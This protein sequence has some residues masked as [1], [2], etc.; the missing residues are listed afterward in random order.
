MSVTRHWILHLIIALSLLSGKVIGY[1]ITVD[2]TSNVAGSDVPG[3]R[4]L[5]FALTYANSNPGPHTIR[6]AAAM[7]NQTFPLTQNFT[8]GQTVTIDG[9]ANTGGYKGGQGLNPAGSG[10]WEGSGHSLRIS[11]STSSALTFSA[12]STIRGIAFVAPNANP[13]TGSIIFSGGTTHLMD[14]CYVG[15]RHDN[16]TV[17]MNYQNKA[18]V[19]SGG[20]NVTIRDSVISNAGTT[21]GMGLE[22]TSPNTVLIDGC[23]IGTNPAGTSAVANGNGVISSSV[24]RGGI[25]LGATAAAT[26]IQN[27]LISGNNGSGITNVGASNVMVQDNVIG[28][29]RTKTAVLRNTR[30]GVAFSGGG[31]WTVQNNVI[32][33]NNGA[34]VYCFRTVAF[35]GFNKILNNIIGTDKANG[36]TNYGN[37]YFGIYIDDDMPSSWIKGNTI[38]FTI[39]NPSGWSGQ[40]GAAGLNSLTAAGQGIAVGPNTVASQTSIS[41]NSIYNNAGLGIDLPNWGAVN[42]NDSG[43]GDT[44][45]NGRANFPVLSTAVISASTLT[46]TGWSRPGQVIEFYISDGASGGFGQGRTYIYTATEGVSDGDATTST[47]GTASI[48]GLSQ[49]TDNTNRFSFAIPMKSLNAGACPAVGAKL[50]AIGH[51][52]GSV[53]SGTSNTSEFSGQVTTTG[54]NYTGITILPASLPSTCAV[55][56]PYEPRITYSGGTGAVTLAL[57]DAPSWMTFDPSTGRIGGR[58][59]TV[60]AFSFTITAVDTTGCVSKTYTVTATANTVSGWVWSDTNYDGIWN[61]SEAAI[62]GVTVAIYANGADTVPHTADDTIVVSTSTGAGGNYVLTSGSSITSNYLRISTVPSGTPWVTNTSLGYGMGN[63]LGEGGAWYVYTNALSLANS[64]TSINFGFAAAA[65]AASATNVLQNAS[66]ESGTFTSDGVGLAGSPAA[67][68]YLHATY[69]TVPRTTWY[70]N[71]WLESAPATGSPPYQK[72]RWI[73]TTAAGGAIAGTKL[74]YQPGSVSTTAYGLVYDDARMLHL[75]SEHQ[76]SAWV[77]AFD[78]ANP[79]TSTA[80]VRFEIGHPQPGN[81]TLLPFNTGTMTMSPGGVDDSSPV[82]TATTRILRWNLPS[83][84]PKTTT[85]ATYTGAGGQVLDWRSLNWQKIWVKFTPNSPILRVLLSQ[86]P[87]NG[88]TAVSGGAVWDAAELKPTANGVQCDFGDAGFTIASPLTT[89]FPAAANA[90]STALKIGTNNTDGETFYPSTGTATADNST[91]SGGINDE[92]LDITSRAFFAGSSLDYNVPITLNTATI[93]NARLMVWA[94]WDG[95][96]AVTGADE[97]VTFTPVTINNGTANYPVTFNIPAATATTVAITRYIRFR[98]V[99]GSDTPTFNGLATTFGEVEDYAVTINPPLDFGDLLHPTAAASGFATTTT[100]SIVSTNL[101]LGTTIDAEA[102]VTP[103]AAATVDDIT[104]T[105]SVDDEDGITLLTSTLTAGSTATLRVNA[106]NATLGAAYLHA[107]VDFNNDGI[108]NNTVLNGANGGERLE[109]VRTIPAGT[110]VSTNQNITFSVPASASTGPNRGIRIRLTDQSGTLPTGISGIGEVEDHVA[111]IYSAAGTV[112]TVTNTGT[113]A[114]TSGTLEWA[115]A[116]ANLNA[117]H[118]TIRFNIAGAGPHVINMGATTLAIT[119]PVTIDGFSQNGAVLGN[120]MAGTQHTINIHVTS[121]NSVLTCSANNTIIRGLAIGGVTGAGH[122]IQILPGSDGCLLEGLYIGLAAN[123][124]TASSISQNGIRIEAGYGHIVRNSAVANSAVGASSYS[125]ILIDSSANGVLVENS[126]IGTNATGL[127]AAANATG[128]STGT[129]ELGGILIN[130]PNAIIRNNLVSGNSGIGILNSGPANT[131]I[132]NNIVGMNRTLTVALPNSNHGIDIRGGTNVLIQGNTVAGNTGTGIYLFNSSTL[133]VVTVDRNVVGTIGHGSNFNFGNHRGGIYVDDD[134]ASGSVIS[135]NT[136]AFNDSTGTISGG[137]TSNELTAGQGLWLGPNGAATSVLITQNSFYNNAGLG[138]DIKPAGSTTANTTNLNDNIDADSGPNDLLNFPILSTAAVSGSNLVVTGFVGAGNTVEVFLADGDGSNFG[139][140]K[141]YLFTRTEGSADDTDATTGTY[142]NPVN[143]L[144]QGAITTAVNRFTFTVPLASLPTALTSGNKATATATTY[145][146]PRKTSEFSGVVTI[147][148]IP[149]TDFGDHPGFASASQIASGDIRIGTNPTDTENADLGTADD[150]VG[151]DDEDLTMPVFTVGSSTALSIPVNIPVIGNL[152]GSTAMLNLFVDWNGDGDVADQ[153]ETQTEQ[154]VISSGTRSFSLKPPYG[155]TAGTKYLRIRLSESSAVPA[156]AGASTLKGEVEDYAVSVVLGSPGSDGQGGIEILPIGTYI[157]PMDNALQGNFNLKSYGLAVRL[158]HANVPLKWII[159]PA[160]GKDGVDFAANA[161]RIKPTAIA[162]SNLSFRS[163][164]IAIHP[165]FESQALAVINAYGNNVAV[166]QLNAA[167]SVNVD[168]TLI[169]KPRVAVFDQGGNGHLHTDILLEAG[170]TVGT[171]YQ[172]LIDATHI[173]AGSCFTSATEPHTGHV[174]GAEALMNFLLSGGNFFG[175]CEAVEHYLGQGLLS[176]F[177]EKG[178]LGGTM[179]FDN[180]QDPMAQF[181]GGLA[182]DG[183]SVESF[184]M[185]SNPGCRIAYSSTDG[186]RYKAYAGRVGGAP[187]RGGWVQYLAG[188]NYSGTDIA[189]INGRRMLLNSVLRPAGRPDSCN[190]TIPL[191]YGDWNGTDLVGSYVD[192]DRLRLGNTVEAEMFIT[193]NTNATADDTTGIDDE[194]GVTM[195]ATLTQAATVTI[196]V[197]VFNNTGGTRY[198]HAW[199]DFNNDHTFD[200]ALVSAGGERLEAVRSVASSATASNQNITFVVPTSA[201]VGT[202]RGVRF[203]ISDSTTTTPTSTPTSTGGVGEVEDYIVEIKTSLAAGNLVYV[204]NNDNGRF[205]VG[206]GAGNIVVQAKRV[207]DNIVVG[208]AITDAA[209]L[210]QITGLTPGNYY[211][212]IPASEFASGKSLFGKFSMVGNGGDSGR[213]DDLDESGIDDSAPAT[214]GIRSPNIALAEAGE[215]TAGETGQDGNWDDGVSGR[216]ADNNTDLTIDFGFSPCY[217]TNLMVN[218]SFENASTTAPQWTGTNTFVDPNNSTDLRTNTGNYNILNWGYDRGS[219]IQSPTRTTDGNRMLFI[220]A[221]NRAWYDFSIDA[222]TSGLPQLASGKYYTVTFDWAPFDDSSAATSPAILPRVEVQTGDLAAWASTSLNIAQAYDMLDHASGTTVSTAQTTTSWNTLN[223]RRQSMSFFLPTPIAGQKAVQILLTMEQATGSTGGGLIDNVVVRETCSP[224]SL[225]TVGNLV[226]NDLNNDGN[227]DAGEGV[228]NVPVRLFRSTQTKNDY[229]PVAMATTNTDGRYLFSGLA[230][231][232]Y[233]IHI[234]GGQFG[235]GKPLENT[236]SIAPAS[237]TDDALDDNASSNDN[238]IDSATPATGGIQSNTFTLSIGGEPTGETGF[239]NNLDDASDSNGNLTV[240]FG[241]VALDFGDWNGSGALTTTTSSAMSA[242]LRL[243]ATVD[244]EAGVTPN[245]PATADGADE[246]GVTMPANITQGASVTIPV[247]VYNNNTTGKYLQAWIDFNNDGT[248]NNTDVT[249]GGER[250]HNAVT[251]ANAAAQ[252]VNITF[253]VPAAASAGTQRGVRFRISDNAATTPTSSGAVGEIEDYVT[254]I[255]SDPCLA[256]WVLNKL[257]VVA[258]NNLTMTS[259]GVNGRLIAKNMSITTSGINVGV[260]AGTTPQQYSFAVQTSLTQSASSMNVLSGSAFGYASTMF[261]ASGLTVTYPGGGSLLTTP[262]PDFA[263]I[264][265]AV[266]AEST[267]YAGMLANGTVSNAATAY[268]LTVGSG[269]GT[270]TAV[271]V[272][273]AAQFAGASNG[274][275]SINLNGQNP[276]AII[277]NVQGTAGVTLSNSTIGSAALGPILAWNFFENT[278]TVTFSNTALFGSFLAPLGTINFGTSAVTGSVAA[279]NIT[280]PAGSAVNNP[281]WSGLVCPRPCTVGNLIY[282]DANGNGAFDSGEGVDGVTV[283]L[284]RTGTPTSGTAIATAT[285]A[286]GGLYTMTGI[287]PGQYYLHIPA[288]NFASGQPL[289][290][291]T[292]V[293]STSL[294]D[295]RDHGVDNAAPATNGISSGNFVLAPDAMPTDTTGET[296]VGNTGDNADDDNG[297]LTIDFGFIPP[298][299]RDFG[300]APSYAVATA[301]LTAGTPMFGALVDYESTQPADDNTTGM[302]ED[303]VYVA[304]VGLQG[305][306]LYVNYDANTAVQ[307][308]VNLWV[309]WNRDGDFADAGEQVLTNA[310][311]TTRATGTLKIPV[312]ATATPG[313]SWLRARIGSASG[314]GPSGASI[315]GEVE[316]HAVTIVDGITISGIVFEDT[317][318]N[319]QRDAGEP[320]IPGVPVMVESST[321]DDMTLTNGSGNY[322]LITGPGNSNVRIDYLDSAGF[323]PSAKDVGNDA[324][325]SDFAA[326][327]GSTVISDSFTFTAASADVVNLS[328]GLVPAANTK[329]YFHSGIRQPDNWTTTITL[330]KFSVPNSTLVNA[331]RASLIWPSTDFYV[332]NQAVS[333]ATITAAATVT[334]TSSFPSTADLVS[335]DTRTIPQPAVSLAANDGSNAF[336]PA[337]GLTTVGGYN[338]AAI[339]GFGASGFVGAGLASYIGADTISVPVILEV[340]NTWSGGTTYAS[341]ITHDIIAAHSV[342]YIYATTDFGDWAHATNSSGAATATASS[343]VTS[344][345]RLGATVDAEA[346]VTP[347]AAADADGTDEDGVTMPASIIQGASVTI[348]VSVFNNNT[349]GKYLQAWIDFD[350]DGVFNNTDVASGGERIHNAVTAANA[351]QQTI[352]VTF[353]VP[354]VASVG[355]QRGVRFRLTDN[356]ATTPVSSGA[357]GETEDYVVA[358]AAPAGS[359]YGDY[360]GFPSASSVA[361][362]NLRMGNTVDIETSASTNAAATGDDT[363]DT[364]DEDGASTMP[365][366]LLRGASRVMRVRVTNNTVSDGYLNVWVDF[367]RNGVLTDAGERIASDVVVA[368]GVSGATAQLPFVVPVGAS[369][370]EAGVRFRLSD[371]QNPSPLG[372]AGVGEVEDYVTN[373]IFCSLVG[374]DFERDTVDDVPRT[375]VVGNACILNVPTLTGNKSGGITNSSSTDQGKFQSQNRCWATWET[376]STYT[377]TNKTWSTYAPAGHARTIAFQV[378]LDANSSGSIDALSFYAIRVDDGTASTTA[379]PANLTVH[380]WKQ[381][382]ANAVWQESKTLTPINR[383]GASMDNLPWDS[384]LLT[385]NFTGSWRNTSLGGAKLLFEIHAVAPGSNGSL[386]DRIDFDCFCLQGS[387]VCPNTDYGDWNGSGAATTTA[388]SIASPNLRLG[389]TVDTETSVTPDAAATAD[390]ADEDGVTMPLSL[391]QGSSATIPVSVFNNNTAGTYLQAWIDFNNDGVFNNTDA[392][393]GGDRIYNALTSASASTQTLNV[394]FTIPLGSSIGAQRGVRF[395]LSNSAATT[396]TSSG[397][398]GEIED[399]VVSIQPCTGTEESQRF[400]IIGLANSGQGDAIALSNGEIGADRTILSQGTTSPTGASFLDNDGVFDQRW[401]DT[402][403]DGRRDKVRHPTSSA[404][405]GPAEVIDYS[406]SMALPSAAGRIAVSDTDIFADLGG[407]DSALAG[408]GVLAQTSTVAAA[409]PSGGS[410]SDYFASGRAANNPNG[411]IASSPSGATALGVRANINLTP[412]RAEIDNLRI[413][414]EAQSAE[415]TLNTDIVSRNWKDSPGSGP[416]VTNVAGMDSNGDGIVIVDVN[417][418]GNNF[419]VENSDWFIDGPSGVTVIIRVT[420]TS[421]MLLSNAT[422]Q[423]GEGGIRGSGVGTASIILYKGSS[424][425]NT[426]DTVFGFSNVVLDHVAVWELNGG[427]S[428]TGGNLINISNGQGSA[429]FIGSKIDLANCRFNRVAPCLTPVASGFDFGDLA[430]TAPGTGTGNYETLLANNGPRHYIAPG[431]KLGSVIDPEEDGLQ[432]ANA[433]G[434]GTDDDGFDPVAYSVGFVPGYTTNVTISL[435]N[436]AVAAK[437][438]GFVDLNNDGDFADSGEALATLTVPA[439]ATSVILP[440]VIPFSSSV[441]T[442]TPLGMRLRLTHDTLVTTGGAAAL[443]AATDGEVED[444][445]ITI[446]SCLVVT[447]TNDSGIGSLRAAIQCANATPGLDT[448]TFAISGGGVKTIT[449]AS[450]LPDITDPLIIDGLSQPGAVANSLATGNNATLLIEVNGATYNVF[451]FTTGSSG[452]S[453]KGMIINRGAFGVLVDVANVTILGNFIGTNAAGASAL[454]NTTGISIVGVTGAQIGGTAP[455]ARNVISGNAV[456]GIEFVSGATGNNIQGNYIGTNA[457]GTGAVA[458][459]LS[460]IDLASGANNNTIGGATAGSGNVVSGNGRDGI[461]VQTTG[462]AIHGNYVGTNAAGTGLLGNGEHGIEITS[463]SNSIGGVNPGEPNIIA[464][465]GTG[466]ILVSGGA[467]QTVSMRRNSIYGNTGPGIDLGTVAGISPNNGTRSSS[468]SN[469]DMDYPIITGAS[470]SGTDLTVSGFVGSVLAGAATWS[471]SYVEI[472][473]TDNSPADQGGEVISGDGASQ[474]HGEGRYYIGT[475][476]TNGV[477]V[478]SGTV[479]IPGAVQSLITGTSIYTATATDAA[480]NTSEFGA[481]AAL[482]FGD[483]QD[484]LASTAAGDYQTRVANNGPRHMT[485][486]ALRL[487]STITTELD[488]LSNSTATGDTGDDGLTTLPA[489]TAGVNSTPFNIAVTN[490]GAAAKLSVWIDFNNNGNFADAGEQVASDLNV[491]TSATSVSVPSIAIP[492]AAVQGT[493]LGM[494]VRLST[495]ASLT[496]LGLALDGEVEDYLISILSPATVGNMV[497]L[498]TNLDGILN[499]GEGGLGGVTVQLHDATGAAVSGKSTTTAAS[500]AWSIS[501][502]APGLYTVQ[503]AIPNTHTFSLL[504]QGTN[505]TLDSDVTPYNGRSSGFWL[506]SGQSRTDIDAGVCVIPALGDRVWRD[507]NGDGIQNA[508]ETTGVSGV[509][510]TLYDSLGAPVAGKTATSNASGAWSIANV[511]AGTY[512]VGFGI[513]SGHFASPQNQGADDLV[514]SD[515]DSSGRTGS[516][517]IGTVLRQYGSYP[518]DPAISTSGDADIFWDSVTT[519]YNPSTKQLRLRTVVTATNSADMPETITAVISEGL[520]PAF[521]SSTHAVFFMDYSTGSPRLSVYR[522][523]FDIAAAANPTSAGVI[524]NIS[525]TSGAL[526]VTTSGFT[527]TFDFTIDATPIISYAGGSWIGTGYDSKL[528]LSLRSWGRSPTVTYASN[529]ITS[530]NPNWGS[531]TEG[532][533]LWNV[534]NFSTSSGCFVARTDIDFG[535]RPDTDYGDL[536][537]IAAGTGASNYETLSINNGPAHY[538]NAN[539]RLGATWDGESD[540]QQSSNANGDDNGGIDDED[541]IASFPTFTQGNPASSD[542]SVSVYNNTGSTAKLFGFIDWNGDGDFGDAGEVLTPVNVNSSATLQ[543]VPLPA[544]TVPGNAFIGQVGARFRLSSDSSLTAVGWSGSGEVE[545]YLITMN[546][547]MDV[548]DLVFLDA[549]Q[550]GV[551]DAGDSGLGGLTLELF[552]V[553]PDN[554][555]GGGDDV[556]KG[557][558]VSAALTGAYSFTGIPAGKY[559]IRIATPPGSAAFSSGSQVSVDNG[560][561]QDNNGV[562]P[563]GIGTVVNSPV[564]TL[565]TNSEPN[566]GVGGNNDY[567]IDFGFRGVPNPNIIVEYRME[568]SELNPPPSKANPTNKTACLTQTASGDQLIELGNGITGITTNTGTSLNGPKKPGTRSSSIHGWDTTADAA[569]T[570]VRTSLDPTLDSVSARF[571]F[572][573]ATTGTL[574]NVCF[575]VYRSDT[576]APT[577]ARAALTWMEGGAYR[578]AYSNAF[579]ITNLQSWMTANLP[580]TSF[581]SGTTAL[582][583]GYELAGKTFL[584]EVY[585][586]G[587]TGTELTGVVELDNVIMEGNVTCVPYMDYGDLRD[588]VAGPASSDYTTLFANDGP[589]HIVTA[590]LRIGAAI[591]AEVD[592]LHNAAADGDSGDDAFSVLPALTAGTSSGTWSIP[593]VNS[594]ASANFSLWID[595][596]ANGSFEDAGEKVAGDL[597]VTTGAT[598]VTVPSFVVPSSASTTGAVGMRM[599]LSTTVGLTSIGEAPNGEVEDYVITIADPVSLGNLV[600]HDANL[601]GLN[602]NGELGISGVSVELYSTTD[603]NIGN[604]DDTYLATTITNSEGKYLFNYLRAGK[605]YIKIQPPPAYPLATVNVVNAD[606]QVNDDNN[607]VQVGL[608]GTTIQSPVVTL[609]QGSESVADGDASAETDLTVDIGLRPCTTISIT[610]PTLPPGNVNSGYAQPLSASGG[611]GSYSFAK[612]AGNLPAGLSLAASGVVSGTPAEAGTFSFT[613]SATDVLGCVGTQVVNLTIRPLPTIHAIAKDDAGRYVMGGEFYE[614][615]GVFRTNLVRLLPDGSV[616]TTFNPDVPNGVVYCIAL[617]GNAIYV[618]GAFTTW[619]AATQNLLVKLDATTGSRDS[620]FAGHVLSGDTGAVV[621]AIS[622]NGFYVCGRFN[623]PSNGIAALDPSTGAV[624]SGFNPAGPGSGATLFDCFYDGSRIVTVGDFSTFNGSARQGIAPLTLTGGFDN[625]WTGVPPANAPARSLLQLPLVSDLVMAGDFTSY[626]GSSGLTGTARINNNTGGIIPGYTSNTDLSIIK[627]HKVK[628]AQ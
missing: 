414:I 234:E 33:G 307:A 534:S 225:L 581:V 588:L 510:V 535:L 355:T 308:Y 284:F 365:R 174:N 330:P 56:F 215:P 529:A 543:T 440:V 361:S 336:N 222:Q 478:F 21:G 71:Y 164:P 578:T 243:G 103:N 107:W 569:F 298:P 179:T 282:S 260:D 86:T 328:A 74:I 81:N 621:H 396:P 363:A 72:S 496:S 379:S 471:G 481:M 176:G 266:D 51:I 354:G 54:T 511:A 397:A 513:P 213:D 388:S 197:S 357:V 612:I 582:P 89:A 625:T 573:A 430:D 324:T 15:V 37:G 242:N 583:A 247:S 249:S 165:G 367:N 131:I 48:N 115:I 148:N 446:T 301:T 23:F 327:I 44:G 122:G 517:T 389:A 601:D 83:S 144:N 611:T 600:W 150:N 528:G 279:N 151:T 461:R 358:I 545:D 406:G 17:G 607:G 299:T 50:T 411:I 530:W 352:N 604:G 75:G 362:T 79:S 505:R 28:L 13:T 52:G 2:T 552:S 483:L 119:Q 109:A 438:Y 32:A 577:Q 512:S 218:G 378:D 522:Y 250:V 270:G 380:V 65:S 303:G 339:E 469:D 533:S 264:Y 350:N 423:P 568:A 267:A 561:D 280:L 211:L 547:W 177:V 466:G 614:V 289:S 473:L 26:T 200:D 566:G 492:G 124:T 236:L 204:D 487:G 559:F 292:S 253:T 356:N 426:S 602:N 304:S 142:G 80:R 166:H 399:Y 94:D 194:D 502:I 541:G 273:S 320:G 108:F 55:N 230:P 595:Y 472:F 331:R 603:G 300:D 441:V 314:V 309:D 53:A 435:A 229:P 121:T 76:L 285:T 392:S 227:Y 542:I 140:G 408:V 507:D 217:R 544:P 240:D 465:N 36:S 318:N 311:H 99:E 93:P 170:L 494:R 432:S 155:T 474:P 553:G 22:I 475:L 452:S 321:Y 424:E 608:Q 370:G 376:A 456:R 490:T 509:A 156:F 616:D 453:V 395:R 290:G 202:A 239:A 288:S 272:M 201:S 313:A 455:A 38:C 7:A 580:L 20:S 419:I 183:G 364:D 192:A 605:Y 265:A 97:V 520:T 98:V 158:L 341:K 586:Y 59:T 323:T 385:A 116:Q 276:S 191:D 428:D 572:N 141:T 181:E 219:W 448:I 25:Y 315:D 185:T 514:D 464:G 401:T 84:S 152:S 168:A 77:A 231:G 238:G 610:P 78:P 501:G 626:G 95:D 190:L 546:P 212:F 129:A 493:N 624:V 622:D 491:A 193:P 381:V 104:N 373:I 173:T 92:D 606:D 525:Q 161:S 515:G 259:S 539:L 615:N 19:I 237:P 302:D 12:S 468:Q 571:T 476:T 519:T 560:V 427:S 498:D 521:S 105:G 153:G 550:N 387:L 325:D 149:T 67:M 210:Y 617:R 499:G 374:W 598:V 353:S 437:L 42:T 565:I 375:G 504:H 333:A 334:L 41:Q 459:A 563:G 548:G 293:V 429:Q 252:T 69:P 132:Q 450:E 551:Y 294:L 347:N 400:L 523:S 111:A 263:G 342:T 480:G 24:Y 127:A 135:N 597:V 537:D 574:G 609:T 157:I 110:T 503:F 9:F 246:D 287:N 70:P 345:L 587:G 214:N 120:L 257:N 283:R 261:S 235:A 58:P 518:S 16:T 593:V 167:T 35:T 368:P 477:G 113:G 114:G 295:N 394:N 188:H 195:P 87:G 620:A 136:V 30:H 337:A 186:A 416:Y 319:G 224:A 619:G 359:D 506:T 532:Q 100:S 269:V 18:V 460:G 62:S 118:D 344:N 434:D 371:T 291:S 133:G 73:D 458:N 613:A 10:L 134:I 463:A 123:G 570:S 117:T 316:D 305:R 163:G 128:V 205:D 198:L 281:P 575:D 439:N 348:P 251:T 101:R 39:A 139:E 382:G 162:A 591:T 49:G 538:Y 271:F 329:V 488:A 470:V 296:G 143:G 82:G 422:I 596:N 447:N 46:V 360:S 223:W 112:Y 627:I 349:S 409:F 412:L 233:F 386:N 444:Y 169:H 262:L 592:A 57:I 536:P 206:E 403:S 343:T 405:Y 420:G 209:G 554:L 516:Y 557:T 277:V 442:G 172:L 497:F 90:I 29:N 433:D 226:Y 594:E 5:R 457:A 527:R 187:S 137:S 443:G 479:P 255:V 366:T 130:G 500:G 555:M 417:R 576:F 445:Q 106:H 556:S 451:H 11:I 31:N 306:H 258:K 286:G 332:E 45:P 207:S 317:N 138:I 454:G 4:T 628:N 579:S 384:A 425:G 60:G 415:M 495:A 274:L 64:A 245:A 584:L 524:R 402:N 102:T 254:Q 27:C 40:S 180:F 278:N 8:V 549:N 160:K 171:H 431:I 462:N 623:S 189:S 393:S 66:F 372:A 351:A 63:H 175:Q 346:S 567:T 199:I 203:R 232:S 340:T 599:R 47:Y 6:F 338:G 531:G 196:P 485:R 228:A 383:A 326:L 564:F 216:P 322:S 407:F 390:G 125:G 369:L 154:T 68:M 96:G 467:A 146:T 241:F 220:R 618:G 449:L 310:S 436:T 91:A 184:K 1:D 410:A 248:F 126:L 61:N 508:S 147:N 312:P 14:A 275:I 221:D 562:Q 335:S 489:L 413:W 421:N 482:D 391:R 182:D 484:V 256:G 404:F 590:E 558:T 208:T 585:L 540:G 159:N 377:T 145:P 85:G 297:N 268:T 526:T 486:S 88:T 418:S 398:V 244:S 43:D 178:L 34:G 3:N 589:R